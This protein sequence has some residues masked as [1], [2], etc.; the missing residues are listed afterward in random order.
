MRYRTLLCVVLAIVTLGIYLQTGNH[1]F[2]NF[3]DTIYVTENQHVQRGLTAA[4]IAWAFTATAASNWHPVTWISHM[5]DVQLFGMNP[6]GHHLTNV[7]IHTASALFLFLLLVQ[8]TGVT[9]QSFF[10]AALFALHPLH[11][12]SVAWV[13]ERKDVLSCFFMLLTIW[14]YVR[15]TKHKGTKLYLLALGTF[16]L[17]LMAKPML[18]TLPGVLI[19]LDYW[20]LQ[21]I[22]SSKGSR[23]ILV[24][25][26]PFFFLSIASAVITIYAQHHGGAMKNLDAIPLPL[27]MENAAVA[28]LQYIIK[29]FWPRDLALLYPFPS[30]IPLWESMGAGI[31]LIAITLMVISFGK[32]LP[33]LAVGWFWYLI[34]LVPVIGIVQVGGQSMADRY[35]YIPLIGLFIAISWGGTELFY[36]KHYQKMVLAFLG[37]VAVIACAA[38]TWHQLGYWKDNLTLYR[39]TLDVTSNNYLILNNYGIAMDESGDHEAALR[40]YQEALRVWPKSANAHINMGVVYDHEE[41]FAEAVTQ[42]REALRLQPDYVLAHINLAK[43]LAN[44]GNTT[45]AIMQFEQALKIDPNLPEAHLKLA[46]I[47]MGTGNHNAAIQHYEA[48]L[49]LDPH[50]VKA[51]VTMGVTLA[52]EG[53]MEEAAGY[54]AQAVQVDPNSVEAQFNLALALVKL[55][56]NEEARQHF[57]QVLRLKPDAGAARQWLD[58]LSH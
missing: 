15:Y 8:L 10:V 46:L 45:D 17:G 2:I 44:M 25:K 38:M 12:E 36:G 37:G 33:Y 22:P 35:S 41:R 31:I 53:K 43:A 11:V 4:N 28:Y 40:L 48:A 5:A 20:P 52:K 57:Y 19:L 6:S 32:K 30:S 27:R 42:Y 51:P 26:I 50:F 39:H 13:A 29:M 54:F 23:S 18:I 47:M 55:G 34:T 7:V 49:K 16:A 21:R 24:E 14:F 58:K 1:Q 9:W 3:D 56:R